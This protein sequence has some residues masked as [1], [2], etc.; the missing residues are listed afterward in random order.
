VNHSFLSYRIDSDRLLREAEKELASTMGAAAIEAER[1][2]VQVI[3]EVLMADGSLVG[4][5]QPSLQLGDDAVNPW[6]QLG[7]SP[8]F[9]L[10]NVIS[11][12]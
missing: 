11:C 1:E 7:G 6:D 2:L 9:P 12:S 4:P 8:L 5:D 3:F 10:S